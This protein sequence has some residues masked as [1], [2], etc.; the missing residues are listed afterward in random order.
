MNRRAHGFT[1]VELLVAVAIFAAV[2]AIAYGGLAQIAQTRQSLAA[3]QDRFAAL[4]RAM[5]DVGRDL[6]QAIARPV[7]G[8]YGET[9]P[10]LRGSSDSLELSRLGFAN[11]LAE[12][13]SNVERVVYALVDRKL[14][15]G[16]HAV[17]DRAPGSVPAD[18]DLLDRV[19]RLRWR[20]LD[21]QGN[22]SDQWPSTAIVPVLPGVQPVPREQDL[23]RA[24]EMTLDL[25]DYGEL[26]RVIALPAAI[27]PA[28]PRAAGPPPP[29]PGPGTPAPPTFGVPLPAVPA[30]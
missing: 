21:R 11:P 1:L 12:P 24:V 9:I 18:R 19:Q 16:R 3:E 17:L 6:R 5:S 14:R 20:Y 10:A 2:S 25:E 28:A 23:P 4:T 15:R 27:P 26:R 7:R 30:R 8:N 29:P 13:R 22:W